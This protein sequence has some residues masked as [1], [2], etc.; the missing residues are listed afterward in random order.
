MIY[1]L[2]LL[3]IYFQGIYEQGN[4]AVIYY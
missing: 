1:I 3:K 2:H 4:M